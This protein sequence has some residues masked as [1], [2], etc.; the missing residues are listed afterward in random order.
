MRTR[1]KRQAWHRR[2][3]V[4][5]QQTVRRRPARRPCLDRPRECPRPRPSPGGLAL[6][7]LAQAHLGQVL[8]SRVILQAAGRR[9]MGQARL[10]A[11]FH[12]VTPT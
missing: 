10:P 3:H 7:L 2:I 12:G 1:R 5:L 11:L 6:A 8:G 9:G 4:R